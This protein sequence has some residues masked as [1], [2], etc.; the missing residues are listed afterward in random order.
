MIQYIRDSES[1][2]LMVEHDITRAKAMA[3][4][5]FVIENLELIE[6]EVEK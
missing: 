6:I 1:S 5:L 3:D 4:R 2:L